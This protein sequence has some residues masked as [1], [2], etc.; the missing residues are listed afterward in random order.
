MIPSEP[1]GAVTTVHDR[2]TRSEIESYYEQGR[3]RRDSFYDLAVAQASDRP[4][5][6]FVFDSTTSLTYAELREQAL[7]IA[8][9]L[10]R[11]GVGRGDRVVVQL[12]NWTEFPVVALAIARVG[13]IVV[14]VMAI[15]RHAEVDYIVRHSGAVLAVTAGEF[16]R[17]DHVAM[18]QG[19]EGTTLEEVVAVRATEHGLAGATPVA[20]LSVAG[21][22]GE[23][24]A[25]LEGLDG[26]PDD[27]FLIVYTSGTTSRPKGCLHT[28]NTIRATAIA[29]ADAFGYTEDDVQ[30]GPSPITHSSGLVHSVLLPMLVGASSHLMEA[31]DPADALR[32]IDEHRCTAG[33]GATTFLTMMLDAHQEGVHDLSSLR[34]WACAGSPIAGAV[35]ERAA[36]IFQ[37]CRWLS[38]YGRSENFLTT[39]CRYDD[40]PARSVSSDGAA[41]SGSTVQIVGVDGAELPRGEEGDIAYR[42]PSH[43]LEY[44]RDA[45]QTAALFTPSGMSL[46]GDLGR[47]DAEGFVRVTGRTKDIIIRGGMNISAQ[48][49]EGHLAGHPSIASVAVVGMPD[50]RLGEKVCVYAVRKDAS[51]ML[52]LA[53]VNDF[54]REHQ[55]AS[56]K[57]PEHLEVVSAIPLTATGKAQKHLLRADIREKLGP[58]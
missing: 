45:A 15:Y 56:Q 3:W 46:S 54:L 49:I 26:D 18:F 31:W 43:M 25:E 7:R 5:R 9:G 34:Y 36:G 40:P 14:P 22:I 39:M 6:R 50:E 47:M 1:A 19:L 8:V 30:F 48:E 11:R 33:A 44:Y 2:F 29:M 10:H 58:G 42:G 53:D 35:I 23:L 28:F 24:E 12:P 21:P 17:F 37:R 38:V 52:T 27:G 16:R 41:I 13:A 20:E 32:R 51:E 57:L 55:V 4:D